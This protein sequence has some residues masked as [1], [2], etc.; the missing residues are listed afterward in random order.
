MDKG[1]VGCLIEKL[2]SIVFDRNV[3]INFSHLGKNNDYS[4]AIQT[5]LYEFDEEVTGPIGPVHITLNNYLLQDTSE[6]INTID[7][8]I[9]RRK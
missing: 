4:I 8:I 7:K 5:S 1:M 9:A 6:L 2:M 3:E